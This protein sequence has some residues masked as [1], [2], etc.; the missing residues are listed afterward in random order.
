MHAALLSSPN[1][2]TVLEI[3]SGFGDHMLAYART[4]REIDYWPTECNEYLV[5]ELH[6]RILKHGTSNIK[7]PRVL[8]ILEGLW[9]TMSITP[10]N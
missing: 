1:M 5:V 2:R 6:K 3:A 8:D 4:H 7:T 9:Q 10:D